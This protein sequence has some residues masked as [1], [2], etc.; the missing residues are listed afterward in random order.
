MTDRADR[1]EALD[2]RSA[3]SGLNAVARRAGKYAAA[4]AIPISVTASAT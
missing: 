2:Q 4:I 1:H 3:S